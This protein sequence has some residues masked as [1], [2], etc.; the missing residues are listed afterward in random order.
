MGHA[1]AEQRF[2]NFEGVGKWLNECFATKQK[3]F[4]WRGIT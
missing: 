2:S 4:F 1:L 3:Q